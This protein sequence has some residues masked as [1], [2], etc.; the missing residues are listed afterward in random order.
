MVKDIF[1]PKTEEEIE[2]ILKTLSPDKIIDYGAS[3]ENRDIIEYGI[4]KANTKIFLNSYI[5]SKFSSDYYYWELKDINDKWIYLKRISDDSEEKFSF[6]SFSHN[7]KPVYK[8]NR[9]Y[10][11]LK[12]IVNNFNKILKILNKNN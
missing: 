4:E 2:E 6:I 12:D 7:F 8:E 10:K 1:K 9:Q 11:E 3:I 5:P